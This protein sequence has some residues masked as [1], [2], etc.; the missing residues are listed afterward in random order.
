MIDATE[1]ARLF[2]MY[3]FEQEYY[4]QGYTRVA[5]CDEAG[6]GPLAGPVVAAA[7]I[8]PPRCVLESLNDSKKLTEKKRLVLEA[9]IKEKAVAWAV[10]RVE[11]DEIDE[12]NILEA[13]LKAMATA[14]EALSPAAAA[15]LIDGPFG[16]RQTEVPQLAMEKGDAL[17]ASIAAA[18]I[19]AKNE[20][21]RIMVAY[22]ELYPVYGFEK[23]KGYPTAFHR[24]MIKEHGLSPIHRKTFKVK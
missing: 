1:K 14:V 12:I 5:G 20:R 23:H 2:A 6:R 8:L 17:S 19:L 3:R 11:A 10:A 13:S 15:V 7:V 16:L 22:H 24:E 4:D 21:D 18:S 9:E